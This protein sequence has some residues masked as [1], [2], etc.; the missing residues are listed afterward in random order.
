MNNFIDIR[1]LE[2]EEEIYETS[3]AVCPYCGFINEPDCE[4]EEF[5]NDGYYVF[6][7]E[8][9]NKNFNLETCIRHSYTTSK[10]KECE[11]E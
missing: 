4:S 2:D 8:H 6:T 3:G 9:C 5:Y 7:C 10:I 11:V 1:G